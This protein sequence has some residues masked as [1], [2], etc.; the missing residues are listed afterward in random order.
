MG[1]P[2]RNLNPTRNPQTAVAIVVGLAF[3]WLPSALAPAA[4]AGNQSVQLAA[5][6]IPERLGHGTSIGLGFEIGGSAGIPPPLRIVDL[7]YPANFGVALSGLGLDT[8]SAATLE[9]AG[10]A[11]CPPNSIMGHGSA[12]GE[13]P[14]GPSIIHEG[15]TVTIARAEDQNGHIAL[16]F[17]AQ[18]ISPV[19]ANIV[20]PGL[21]LPARQPYGGDIRIAVPLVPSL[22][23]APD[24]AVVALHAML[25]PQGLTYYEQVDGVTVPYTP[26]GILLPERC[27]AAGFPFSATLAFQSG[28][29][30]TASTRVRCPAKAA[31]HHGRRHRHR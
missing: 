12:L 14:F 2:T 4:Y 9:T 18:G 5:R 19:Q 22:P 20:F 29:R 25:G 28:E 17:D 11:G 31:H 23:E 6:L 30:E 13:I 27:P 24:V 26:K 15:A 16:L 8:C 21:L 7:R 10:P 3:A 1:A